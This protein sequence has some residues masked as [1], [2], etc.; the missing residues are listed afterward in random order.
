MGGRAGGLGSKA[1]EGRAAQAAERPSVRPGASGGTWQTRRRWSPAGGGGGY[2]KKGYTWVAPQE[3]RGGWG[4][5]ACV[6]TEGRN[7]VLAMLD[8][9]SCHTGAPSSGI[10]PVEAAGA[11]GLCPLAV[12]EAQRR[13]RS[14]LPGRSLLSR[15]VVD[16]VDMGDG[17]RAG[18]ARPA[19][20]EAGPSRRRLCTASTLDWNPVALGSAVVSLRG[21]Q[22]IMWFT[23]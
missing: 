2:P 10:A 22:G 4:G 5:L 13:T 17:D 19:A 11:R 1:R 6:C 12:E 15:A 18:A 23:K 7:G 9:R 21:K 16:G 3:E 14:D 20:P 8:P